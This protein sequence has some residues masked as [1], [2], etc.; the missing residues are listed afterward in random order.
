[1]SASRRGGPTWTPTG[2]QRKGGRKRHDGRPRRPSSR[3]G[4]PTIRASRSPR[5]GGFAPEQWY[6]SVDGHRFSFRE[7]HDEWRIELDLRPSGRFAR[8][9][10]GGDLD[11]ED[12]RSSRKQMLWWVLSAGKPETRAAR[13]DKI[14]GEAAEGRRAQ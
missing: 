3:C 5:S 1:M 11:D 6:G 10:V 9:W 14:V 8:V 4:S 7:R 12:A 13:I 2:S